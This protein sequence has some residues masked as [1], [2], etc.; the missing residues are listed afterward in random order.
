M[1]VGRML[2]RTVGLDQELNSVS[3]EAQLLFLMSIPHLDRDGL[4]IGEALP[5]LG[6]VL[7]LRPDFFPRYEQ[8]IAELI[9]C[10]I[11]TRYQTKKGRVLFFPGFRK[12][13]TFSYT[14]EGASI[15]DPPPGYIRT[16]SGIEPDKHATGSVVTQELL[17][18]DS[19]VTPDHYTLKISKDKISKDNNA[20]K[21]AQTRKNRFQDETPMTL[22][23]YVNSMKSSPL[24]H[25]QI[26]G[27][28]A[29]AEGPKFT[30]KGQ[31]H[32]FTSRNARIAKTLTPYSSEQIEKAYH[33]MLKD[34][35]H[36]ERGKKVGFISKYTLETLAKYIDRI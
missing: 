36:T 26:I 13:Q 35:V 23:E 20:R 16:P 5:H 4:I 11:V 34:V 31:W 9:D 10:E 17:P 3:V 30:T 8:L 19:G 33:L 29:E 6:T 28:W 32:S 12:N 24:R 7:P 2:N 22:D 18:T 27:E 15:F 25:V 14:R 21:N 1:A